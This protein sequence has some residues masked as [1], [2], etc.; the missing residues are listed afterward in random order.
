MC[1]GLSYCDM[2]KLYYEAKW[3]TIILFFVA[4]AFFGALGLFT[5]V[6]N[7]GQVYGLQKV[8]PPKNPKYPFINPLLAIADEGGQNFLTNLS[9]E[10][11]LNAAAG[12]AK[13]KAL[14][15]SG[16][17]FRDIEDGRWVDINA[18]QTFAP[19]RFL[20]MPLMIAFF[21]QAETDPGI[22]DK[23]V[24]YTGTSTSELQVDS[25]VSPEEGQTY[26]VSDL[27]RESVLAD[28]NHTAEILLN[29]VDK[30]ELADIYSELGMNFLEDK[31]SADHISIKQYTL[32]FRVLY[33]ATYL[34][35]EMSN[36]AL[37]LLSDTPRTIGFATSLPNDIP[38]AHRYHTQKLS[39]GKI[40]VSDCG[41]VYYPD[42]PYELCI[43]LIGPDQSATDRA[44]DA[45]SQVIY[46]DMKNR[47]VST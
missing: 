37:A 27:I 17:Y 42:H 45:M 10:S 8:H 46:Q 5:F 35:R 31:N 20:K 14:A 11:R 9:L 29:L 2:N 16:F 47:H 44:I 23:L 13:N 26:S 15:N 38:I 18:S 32:F 34:S 22:L 30:K 3:F 25:V 7:G 41:V 40:E 1:S 21:K 12:F 36:T 6:F 33:D 24:L 19:G 39:D 28:D 43:S 4:G